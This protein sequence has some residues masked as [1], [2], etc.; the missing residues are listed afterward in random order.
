V[1]NNKPVIVA[2]QFVTKI[3]NG[4]D[5]DR[6]KISEE[7]TTDEAHILDLVTRYARHENDEFEVSHRS[8]KKWGGGVWEATIEA[9]VIDP[10]GLKD[11]AISA[12]HDNWCEGE[13]L[14]RKLAWLEDCS[15]S[16]LV[17]EIVTASNDANFFC[18]GIKIGDIHLAKPIHTTFPKF[19]RDEDASPSP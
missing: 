1:S 16:H 12:V 4:K 2:Y 10:A 13:V 18:H 3:V 11:R 6:Y 5:F 9:V 14:D 7:A 17:A 15:E 19:S 8:L